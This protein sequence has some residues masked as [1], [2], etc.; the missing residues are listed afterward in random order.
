[1]AHLDATNSDR[2]CA[3]H[4]RLSTLD[5]EPRR[6]IGNLSSAQRPCPSA[7]ASISN[8]AC[9]DTDLQA[10]GTTQHILILFSHLNVF[11]ETSMPNSVTITSLDCGTIGTKGHLTSSSTSTMSTTTRSPAR[12]TAR[13]IAWE[14]G[15]GDCV[16]EQR[17]IK[18]Y[19]AHLKESIAEAA[20]GTDWRYQRF[21]TYKTSSDG[22]FKLEASH[23]C[24]VS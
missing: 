20:E 1:M 16:N 22:T 18:E 12:I 4:S 9:S 8:S 2:G 24:S 10:E 19:I 15:T 23:Y 5:T 6:T 17:L 11:L 14:G 7:N 13:L 21:K 3:G